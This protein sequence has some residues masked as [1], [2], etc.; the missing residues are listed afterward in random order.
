MD[1]SLKLKLVTS[2]ILAAV[3]HMSSAY[4]DEAVKTEEA[5]PVVQEAA[6]VA[7]AATAEVAPAEAAPAA[8]ADTA[9][10]SLDKIVV[11]G[12][13]NKIS[14]MKSSVSISTLNAE[15]VKN[16][17][18][19]NSAEVLRNI[20]GMRS[21]AS[22]GESNFNLTSRG[23]PISA[24]GARWVQIQEDGLPITQI[25]DLN[26]GTPDTWLRI[27]QG[28]DKLEVIRGGSSS[29]LAT[30]A[31][32]GIVNF[33]SQT[34]EQKGGKIG[35]STGLNF[36]EY[37][38]DFSYGGP[39]DDNGLRGFVSGFYRNG[40]GVREAGTTMEQGGQIK[41]NIT[42]ELDHGYARINFKYLD[43]KTPANLRVP[44][45]GANGSISEVSGIDP[46]TISFYDLGIVDVARTRENGLSST[47]LTDGVQAQSKAIG[48]E[49]SY[50]FDGWVLA[51]KFRWQDNSGSWM[52]VHTASQLAADN[53]FTAV[54]FNTKLHDFGLTANDAKLSKV[55]DLESAGKITPTVGLYT[56]WQNVSS[57]WSFNAYTVNALT[58]TA[59]FLNNSTD[60][61]G[62]CC[63]RDLDAEYQTVSPYA[64]LAWEIDKFNFD[65]SVRHD[66]QDVTG[67]YVTATANSGGATSGTFDSANRHVIDYSI[68]HTSYSVGV[69]YRINPNLAVFGRASNGVAFNGDRIMFGSANLNGG[70]IPI[71]EA[72]QYEVGVKW[73]EGNFNTFITL[74]DA[75]VEESNYDASTNTASSNKYDNKGVEV[76]AGYS[77]G[78]FRVNGGVTYT[79]AKTLDLPA[80]SST[81]V[82]RQAEWVY[83]VSPSYR[84]NDKLTFIGNLVGTTSS[85]DSST[86]DLLPAYAIVNAGIKYDYDKHVQLSLTANNIFNSIGY[87]E[88]DMG[89]YSARSV[90]GRAVRAAVVYSF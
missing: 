20:P 79:H 3:A 76:E 37:R 83:Q 82:Q 50:D 8:A 61:W 53:T 54:V 58:K 86:D 1:K 23:L 44:T 90:D 39:I 69:N 65:A 88:T 63:T 51:D 34:G 47:S 21:E 68:D 77:I 9:P 17:G 85:R 40:E 31:P 4:A 18:A 5:T 84:F 11:T 81:D 64:A 59:T 13:A 74:F 2:A 36:R 14:K 42:K 52:G 35:F 46:R 10:L 19:A 62:N 87:T 72:D 26:F 22:G 45:N 70:V 38:T 48:A 33:I 27:D 7:E 30:S 80:G 43:D 71:N 6:P 28:L 73:R 16:T 25:G 57:T 32:G 41:G 60:Q 56:S 89:G 24:G 29:T 55:F 12:S 78:N 49:F 75:K 66:T 15:Q 67:Y